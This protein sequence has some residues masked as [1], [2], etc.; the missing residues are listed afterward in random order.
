MSST[1]ANAC[2]FCLAELP[3]GAAKCRYCAE[4]LNLDQVQHLRRK[5][6]GEASSEK[7]GEEVKFNANP[8]MARNNP[9]AF[10][11]GV[12]VLLAG[13]GL[14]G[15]AVF[16]QAGQTRLICFIL[17]LVLLVLACLAFFIW[18]LTTKYTSLVVTTRRTKLRRG[19]LDKHT[20]DILHED[21]RNIQVKQAFIQRMFGVGSLAISSSGQSE[22]EI[23]VNGIRH[24]LQVKQLI[25]RYR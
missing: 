11:V 9:I 22:M 18:W 6:Q 4:V 20:N 10:L 1:A 8:S 13:G 5:I 3:T 7:G 14:L 19:I 23:I 2:P 24:P 17:G 12:L 21:V 15:F 16:Q 25:D